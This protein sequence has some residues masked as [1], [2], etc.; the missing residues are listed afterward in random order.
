LQEL[1]EAEFDLSLTG[2]DPKEID[3][4]LLVPDED[5]KA[6]A[7]PPTRL[8]ATSSIPSGATAQA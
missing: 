7:A 4:L 3:D 2:F 1:N 8:T 5:E 6:N